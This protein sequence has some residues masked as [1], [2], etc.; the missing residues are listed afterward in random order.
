M[1]LRMIECSPEDRE[2]VALSPRQYVKT[3]RD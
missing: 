1:A 2:T 3:K